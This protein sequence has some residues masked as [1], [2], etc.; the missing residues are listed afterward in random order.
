ML[1]KRLEQLKKEKVVNTP[2]RIYIMFPQDIASD[3]PGTGGNEDDEGSTVSVTDST[4]EAVVKQ[5]GL[6][7]SSIPENTTLVQDPKNVNVLGK[8][9]MGF[10][11]IRK[12]DTPIGKDRNVYDSSGN[13][14]R[15]N[16]TADP[17]VSD[18]RFSQD[19]DIA[20]AINTVLLNSDYAPV[21]LSDGGVDKSGFRTWWR[22]DIQVYNISDNSNMAKTGT[23]PKIIVYRVVPYKVH[24]SKVS[25]PNS[26]SAGYENVAVEVVKQYDYIYTGKNKDIIT[27]NV[28]IDTTFSAIMGASTS[29]H[30]GDAA[31]AD[32]ASGASSKEEKLEPIP[33][34]KAPSTAPGA[35]PT[36]VR[37]SLTK[38]KLDKKG[39]GGG[40]ETEE[41]RAA[42]LFHDAVQD[43]SAMQKLEMT[44]IGDPYYIAHSGVSN[45]T[46][47]P[48]QFY[49][50]NS[51]GSINHQNGEV[52]IIVNFRSPI[53][54]NQASGLY[55]F[56]KSTNTAPVLAFSGLY[57][58]L[59]V[60]NHFS[61]GQFTQTLI[62][63]RRPS[64]EIPGPGS[65]KSSLSTSTPS[66]DPAPADPPNQ[67]DSK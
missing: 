62:G 15:G 65:N 32:Q 51:D 28:S 2:D 26:K 52:D 29:K 1:N 8:A 41:T 13:I 27:F 56:G 55:D 9:K 16:N 31:L 64:Q 36:S 19:T 46:A 40:L 23:K 66:P 20:T 48:S 60:Q 39:A 3:P 47:T 54:I 59:T 25:S 63:N 30:S 42:K 57:H 67:G 50:L 58:L 35:I 24:S 37:N 44:I 10:S 21:A 34:G 38:T 14:I 61:G 49:N 33:P 18:I 12:G 43:Q 6:V 53:D 45:Y 11:D 7:K 4:T 5:L 22:I 17:Q